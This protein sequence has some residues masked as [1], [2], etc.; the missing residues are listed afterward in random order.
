MRYKQLDGTL[1]PAFDGDGIAPVDLSPGR[2]DYPLLH[3]LALSGSNAVAAGFGGSQYLGGDF[4]LIRFNAATG[5]LDT[6]F[7]GD[8]TA[9]TT[10]ISSGPSGLTSDAT[11][12][13]GL[14]SNEDA[15]YLC[16]VDG[17]AVTDDLCDEN[18]FTIGTALADGSH[19]FEA[20]AIDRYS[21]VDPA[22]ATRSFTV[23]AT[24][25]DGKIRAHPRRRTSSRKARFKFGS[26]EAGSSFS[27]KLDRKPF[28]TCKSP[29]TYRQLKP[30]R[31][32]FKVLA[33][34][35]AGNKEPK[36]AVFRWRVLP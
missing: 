15:R 6:G 23:D 31:H 11:P 1:D 30:G 4:G 35:A 8:T 2:S 29:K 7:D 20:Q 19:S 16:F 12:S 14:S 26:T 24:A 25:P 13:F 33:T 22:G 36:P 18:P 34:D 28:R 17:A 10:T 9:P 5:V 3:G 32:T 21:N 27:C